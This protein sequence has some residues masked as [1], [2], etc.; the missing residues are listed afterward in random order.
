VSDPGG[1]RHLS[2]RGP[3]GAAAGAVLFLHGG[4]EHSTAAVTRYQLAVVRVAIL[5]ADVRRRLAGREVSVW[6]LRFGVRGWNG[7]G[8]G[9]VAD[10]LWALDRVRAAHQGRPCDGELSAGHPPIV[11]AGHSMGARTAL[12]V[13]GSDGVAGVVAL[14]P[15]VP[16][17]E[18]V[19]Q[20]A[21]RRIVVAHG[22]DDRTTD[23]AASRR[24]VD[25]ARD[26][27]GRVSYVEVPG[28]GHAM[29][30]RAGHWHA[31]TAAAITD[32][33]DTP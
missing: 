31:L 12:R 14:A 22:T 6:T 26:A 23:P 24:W 10:A 8:A 4:T 33:L 9:P 7:D 17:G 30:R 2:C 29:L 1:G 20:V 11:L 21:G 3:V 13:A 32:I 25:R 18:P 27:G 28:D 19:A 15:W 16:A 5:A